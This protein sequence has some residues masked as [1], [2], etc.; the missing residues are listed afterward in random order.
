MSSHLTKALNKRAAG[1]S[2]N[3]PLNK[4]MASFQKKKTSNPVAKFT[5]KIN[6]VTDTEYKGPDKKRNKPNYKIP[7]TPKVSGEKWGG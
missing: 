7:P 6:A 2:V 4:W 5:P 3:E 1:P